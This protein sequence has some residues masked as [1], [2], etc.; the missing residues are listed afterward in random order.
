MKNNVKRSLRKTIGGV[1]ALLMLLALLPGNV[2]AAETVASGTCGTSGITWTLDADGAATFTGEGPIPEVEFNGMQNGYFGE[3]SDR[4]KSAVIGSGITGIG[5]YAFA[6]CDEMTEITLPNTVTFIKE[7]AFL[8]CKVTRFELPASVTDISILAFQNNRIQ[9]FAVQTGN[10]NYCAVDGVLF[11]KDMKQLFSYPGGSPGDAYVIPEGVESLCQYAFTSNRILK[12]LTIAASVTDIPS[13]SNNRLEEITVKSG[14]PAY[15]AVDGILFS[16]DRKTLISYPGKKDGT[17]DTVPEGVTAISSNAFKNAALS[18]INLPSSLRTIGSSAFSNCQNLTAIVI[19][20][21]VTEIERGMFLS[22]RKMVSVTIPATVTKIGRQAFSTNMQSLTDVYY[23]GSEA[24]WALIEIAD[25]QN[26]KL[27]DVTIHFGGSSP[28]A[29]LAFRSVTSDKTEASPGDTITWTASAAGGSGTLRYC[30]YVYKDGAVVRKTGYGA[31]ASVSY[32]PEEAG[33]YKVKAFVKDGA[34]ISVS[35]MSGNTLVSAAA[36]PLTVTGL[37]VSKTAA[38]PGETLTWTVSAEG[39]TGTLRYNFYICRDGAVVQ[40]TGYTAAKTASW[41][42]AEAGKYSVKVFVKDSAANI[43]TQ[44]GGS[45]TVAAPAGPLAV[46]AVTANKT[47]AAAGDTITWTASAEGGTGTLRYNFYIC[48]DGTVVQKTGYTTA[49][50]ASWTAAEAGNYAVKV[51]VKDSAGTAVSLMS[52]NT[53]VGADAAPSLAVTGITADK[54]SAAAGETVTWTAS[55]SGS[56][57][58][59]YC[60]YVYK[61]GAVVQKTGYGAEKTLSFT[62]ATAGVYQAKVF[63]KDVTGAAASRMSAKLTVTG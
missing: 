47:S 30:F 40:K 11:T 36:L 13:I 15:C 33:T 14:N 49:R 8:S 55:A 20:D 24:D 29:P 27:N 18:E 1:L 5:I 41:T 3:Y 53:V 39:G 37:T 7:N 10:P 32:T 46:T 22:C 31:A 6:G 62:A 54:T 58:L 43:V 28:A 4:V 51:Y 44:S 25:Y 23:G 34:G 60:F 42:A 12:Y 17:S 26:D 45:V 63:V 59:R 50:T 56:G 48:K 52:G 9:E 38:S 2:R 57:T 35:G 16:K 61:D 19:P 21:G